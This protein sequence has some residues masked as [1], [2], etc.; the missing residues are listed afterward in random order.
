MEQWYLY[1]KLTHVLCSVLPKKNATTREGWSAL[2]GQESPHR[3]LGEGL[4]N[5]FCGLAIRRPVP[6]G[7]VR[8]AFRFGIRQP[9]VAMPGI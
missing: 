7:I 2:G 1:L 5:C 4:V 9:E 6:A 3:L 8:Y